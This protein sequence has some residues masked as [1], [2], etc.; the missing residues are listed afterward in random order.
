MLTSLQKINRVPP[1]ITAADMRIFRIRA[2]FR[3]VSLTL[4][5]G[6]LRASLSTGSTP[7]LCR[8]DKGCFEIVTVTPKLAQ[9]VHSL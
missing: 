5:G 6:L 8:K 4:R 1:K 9:V 3:I 7:R 2:L